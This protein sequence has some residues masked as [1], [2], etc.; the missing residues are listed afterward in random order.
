MWEKFKIYKNYKIN[1]DWRLLY[2]YF[3]ILILLIL[4][5]IYLNLIIIPIV[6]FACIITF[7]GIFRKEQ[8]MIKEISLQF[9]LFLL[10]IGIITGII[11][12]WIIE[13][14]DPYGRPRVSHAIAFVSSITLIFSYQKKSEKIFMKIGRISALF[15][16]IVL[17]SIIFTD[18]IED[19]LQW[20]YGNVQ[21]RS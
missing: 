4:F 17:L 8:I 19:Y 1:K 15:A 11:S 6:F 13:K 3:L 20:Y 2:Q 12:N 9:W 14:I 16:G 10:V 7:Y 18:A 5:D 21:K